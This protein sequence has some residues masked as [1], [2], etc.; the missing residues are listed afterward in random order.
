[1]TYAKRYYLLWGA[2]RSHMHRMN[3][4]LS[5]AKRMR[6]RGHSVTVVLSW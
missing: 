6:A 3:S 2:K 1:M 4:V 5:L